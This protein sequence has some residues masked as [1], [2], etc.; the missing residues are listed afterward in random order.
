MSNKSRLGRGL[1]GLITGA[2]SS[3][4]AKKTAAK[5]VVK[6]AV[7]KT[8][9]A[10]NTSMPPVVPGYSELVVKEIVAN[11]YQPRREINPVQ[12]EELAKSIQAEGLLQPIVVRKKGR[13][14][15]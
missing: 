11:P 12:I 1:G 13:K 8:S 15:E 10:V 7:S 9:V 3:S 2:G 4:P 14:F 6:K 5:K